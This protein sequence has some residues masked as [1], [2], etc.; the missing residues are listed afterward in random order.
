M[1]RCVSECTLL[2]ENSATWS[3]QISYEDSKTP[4]CVHV[5]L[6]FLKFLSVFIIYNKTETCLCIW[7]VCLSVCCLNL[8]NIFQMSWIWYMLYIFAIAWSVLKMVCIRPMVCLQRHTKFF[9]ALWPIGEKCLKLILTHLN[10]TKYDEID[11]G[12]FEL[13]KACFL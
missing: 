1:C 8:V 11:I 10:C 4:E 5:R 3:Y 12:S 13:T 2:W 7:F 9:D 6:R